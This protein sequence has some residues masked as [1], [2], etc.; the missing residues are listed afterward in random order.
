MNQQVTE[1]REEMWSQEETALARERH[2]HSEV[3]EQYQACL[4]A[5]EASA[6]QEIDA[7]RQVLQ[8][9][10]N[11]QSTLQNQI[12]AERDHRVREETTL[13]HELAQLHKQNQDLQLHQEERARAER[14]HGEMEMQR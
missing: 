5:C 3:A 6:N 12:Q 1:E 14:A 9:G 8:Q 10:Q 11:A 7:L 4:R 2:R 13:R